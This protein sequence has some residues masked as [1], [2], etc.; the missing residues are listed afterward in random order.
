MHRVCRDG[1]RKSL[2]RVETSEG[3]T[4]QNRIHW[5][6]KKSGPT[7]QQGR[8]PNDERQRKGKALTPF[9]ALFFGGKV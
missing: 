2:A 3:W 9:S 8:R 6:Q 4:G 1:T 5:Q 7:A